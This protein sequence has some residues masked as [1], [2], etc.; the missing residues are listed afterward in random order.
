MVYETGVMGCKMDVDTSTVDQIEKSR[1]VDVNQ[2]NSAVV[3]VDGTFHYHLYGKKCSQEHFKLYFYFI[4]Q[5]FDFLRYFWLQTINKL[6]CQKYQKVKILKN[7][8]KKFV[9]SKFILKYFLLYNWSLNM[10]LMAAFFSVDSITPYETRTLK[11]PPIGF[12]S[13]I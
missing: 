3:N 6:L 11:F 2:K 10:P 9:I 5:N 13:G 1:M 8:N 7:K 4:F 12:R